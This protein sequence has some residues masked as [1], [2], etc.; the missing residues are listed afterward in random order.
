MAFEDKKVTKPK[1]Q[2]LVIE[3]RE[4]ISISGVLD[5][6]SFNTETIIME[7]ELGLLTIKGDELKISKLNLEIGEMM[8]EGYLGSCVYSEAEDIRTRGLG[9]LSKLFK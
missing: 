1:V 7:T 3:N 2:N 5:V 8:I 6:T 9:F 4:K